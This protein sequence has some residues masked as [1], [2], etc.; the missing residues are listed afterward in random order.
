V[1]ANTFVHRE[2]FA[3][4]IYAFNTECQLVSPTHTGEVDNLYP[5]SVES[6]W[7]KGL[8]ALSIITK[9]LFI[10]CL[11]ALLL[12]ASIAVTVNITGLYEYGFQKY[13]VSQTTGL[14]EVE[15]H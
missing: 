1:S 4:I 2:Y 9:W 7:R 3:C 8:K 11:P 15:L 10:L 12:T 6:L 14:S 5:E 13:G